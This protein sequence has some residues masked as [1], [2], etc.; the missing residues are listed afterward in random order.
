MI[1]GLYLDMFDNYDSMHCLLLFTLT[2]DCVFNINI[3]KSIN[4]LIF[5]DFKIGFIIFGPP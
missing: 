3:H 5:L 1:F 4:I 2:L